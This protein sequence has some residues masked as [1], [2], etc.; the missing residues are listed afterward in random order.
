MSQFYDYIREG[1]PFDVCYTIVENYYRGNSS[2]QLRVRDLH[3]R[4]ELL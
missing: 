2:I 4:E 3:E 1:N